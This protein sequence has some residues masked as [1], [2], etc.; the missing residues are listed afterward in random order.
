MRDLAGF[1]RA[2][3]EDAPL[4]V[5]AALDALA[6]DGPHHSQGEVRDFTITEADGMPAAEGLRSP[7]LFGSARSGRAAHLLVPGGVI[8]PALLPAI[9]ELLA[10]DPEEVRAGARCEGYF[11]AGR[12][13]RDAEATGAG[14]ESGDSGES[15]KSLQSVESVGSLKSLE[16]V[17][18][19]AIFRLL[20]SAAEGRWRARLSAAGHAPA[21][22]VISR[23]PV[24]PTSLRPLELRDGGR[25]MPGAID[26]AYR[27]LL[28]VRGLLERHLPLG[29]PSIYVVRTRRACQLRFEALCRAIDGHPDS[30]RQSD[31]ELPGRVRP[32]GRPEARPPALSPPPPDIPIAVT[33]AGEDSVLLQ[34]P[35]RLFRVRLNDTAVTAN[36]AGPLGTRLICASEAGDRALLGA[37]DGFAILDLHTGA[38]ANDYQPGFIYSRMQEQGEGAGLI[39]VSDSAT[40]W[41]ARLTEVLD[42]PDRAVASPDNHY[43][44]ISDQEGGGG[45]Y[46]GADGVLQWDCA[47]PDREA[48]EAPILDGE[49]RFHRDPE[50]ADVE[51]AEAIDQPQGGSDT[52]FSLSGGKWRLFELGVVSHDG[53][54]W[55]RVVAPNAAARFD[56]TGSRLAIAGREHILIIAVARRPRL[57]YRLTTPQ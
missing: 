48:E 40:G 46:R 8:H 47:R 53:K 32:R 43:L 36:Y 2:R 29:S 38:W 56:R 39:H 4:A 20:E 10:L 55:F 15:V 28:Y 3:G 31:S 57:I 18:A 52:A 22:L 25:K 21:D 27:D 12:L 34:F 11:A 41:I 42:Y 26:L 23:I 54:N 37:T 24:L 51:V 19:P 45:I 17:G 49:G 1:F 6:G 13:V 50:E 7:V 5:L 30:P 33:F 16:S 35:S 14:V 44:W 9:A